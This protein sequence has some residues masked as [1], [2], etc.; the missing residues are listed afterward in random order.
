MADMEYILMLISLESSKPYGDG[1]IAKERLISRYNPLTRAAPSCKD[2]NCSIVMN[3]T[4]T[5][6]DRC[7]LVISALLS[8]KNPPK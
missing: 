2:S 1:I 8:L 7:Y 3:V 6:V 4:T 5:F